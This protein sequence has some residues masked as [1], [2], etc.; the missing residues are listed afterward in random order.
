[1]RSLILIVCLPAVLAA[2][3]ARQIV[4]RAVEMDRKDAEIARNYT[5]LQREVD[6]DLDSSGKPKKTQIRTFDV[7]LQEGSPYRRLVAR[8]DQ[9]LSPAE[10]KQEEEKLQKGIEQRRK[11]TQA[12]RDSRI[13][14]WRRRQ[15]RQREPLRELPDAFD[16][17]LNGEEALNGGEVYVIDGTPKPGYKPRSVSTSFLPKVKLRLWIDKR[18]Y[19]WVKVEMESLDTITFGGFLVRLAKG[20]HLMMEQTRVNGEVWLPKHVTLEASARLILVKGFHK[21][22]DF[23]F[24]DYKKFQT[25]S[26]I[27]STEPIA[28]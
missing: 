18:D 10:Q 2:Q 26:R 12:Q 23:T 13:A 17:R 6:S 24:S 19:Q 1:M 15:E 11:E 14:D 28:K 4:V 21:S 16:F 20:G 3:D 22:L 5:F 25:D 7:T 9:P 8:N 27:V